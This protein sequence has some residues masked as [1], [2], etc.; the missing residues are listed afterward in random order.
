[1][2]G[3]CHVLL[4]WAALVGCCLSVGYVGAQPVQDSHRGATTMRDGQHDF[5]F[6]IGTW[7]T[8]LKRLVHPLS[9]SNEW[10]E[11]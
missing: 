1:M 6:E 3:R 10:A 5:D 2:P 4:L 8:H 9:G 11:Y 7:E